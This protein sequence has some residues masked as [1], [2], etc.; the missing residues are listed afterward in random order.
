MNVNDERLDKMSQRIHYL[1]DKIKK[2]HRK[3]H[4]L[5][6]DISAVNQKLDA[7]VKDTS[8]AFFKA[9]EV[10]GVASREIGELKLRIQ[11]INQQLG[12]MQDQFH[13]HMINYST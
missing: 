8:Q 5:E 12:T 13:Q 11:E 3:S 6:A 9:G 2:M 10:H 1:E 4:S 7:Y